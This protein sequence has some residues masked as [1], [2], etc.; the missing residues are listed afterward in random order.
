MARTVY[1]KRIL[2]RI[3]E[4]KEC[5][6]EVYKKA[7]DSHRDCLLE[8]FE[9]WAK[10]LS[11]WRIPDEWIEQAVRGGLDIN[12]EELHGE[13]FLSYLK[14]EEVHRYSSSEGY[15][16]AVGLDML[17]GATLKNLPRNGIWVAQANSPEMFSESAVKLLL[18]KS[19][20][21]LIS[22]YERG[23]ISVKPVQDY[24]EADRPNSTVISVETNF[25]EIENNTANEL[26]LEEIIKK[27][28][29]A[30]EA[31]ARVWISI[32][33][34]GSIQIQ[35]AIHKLTSDEAVHKHLDV[36]WKEW[37]RHGR[38]VCACC[39]ENTIT[40]EEVLNDAENSD[41]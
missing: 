38:E 14:L 20:R 6:P 33:L 3:G 27:C 1:T 40:R 13:Q 26:V 21:N 31:V 39:K 16:G 2:Y 24:G 10:E 5:W 8:A 35:A 30:D 7:L 37:D 9:E 12:P 4:L 28:E 36:P 17:A 19:D 11:P 22:L 32:E 18:W 23:Y 34:A 41:I 29:A 15:K 25:Q